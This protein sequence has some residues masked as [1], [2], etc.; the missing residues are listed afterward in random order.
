MHASSSRMEMLARYSTL[1]ARLRDD[2]ERALHTEDV[3]TFLEVLFAE[4]TEAG[5]LEYERQID[6]TDAQTYPWSAIRAREV[7]VAGLELDVAL[8]FA[9]PALVLALTRRA[10]LE[11]ELPGDE[12]P[13]QPPQT[14]IAAIENWN[15]AALLGSIAP[16]GWA[17]R[18]DEPR[19]SLDDVDAMVAVVV[20]AAGDMGV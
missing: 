11:P 1:D 19:G 8:A 17:T 4:S 5:R 3:E 13:E 7:S 12:L 15:P 6:Q 16:F 20:N 14:L 2:A 9:P 18:D 10:D